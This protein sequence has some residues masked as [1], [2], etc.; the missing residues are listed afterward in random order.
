MLQ[1]ASLTDDQLST[2]DTYFDILLQ[3]EESMGFKYAWVPLSEAEAGAVFDMDGASSAT[4]IMLCQ[5]HL[6]TRTPDQWSSCRTPSGGPHADEQAL[7][8]DIHHQFCLWC[9]A[10]VRRCKRVA[11][12]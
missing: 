10:E 11:D 3:P 8:E 7:C 5:M 2:P 6:S 1:P 4:V 12:R 9:C